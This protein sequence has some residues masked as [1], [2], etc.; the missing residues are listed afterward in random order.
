MGAACAHLTKPPASRSYTRAYFGGLKTPLRSHHPGRGRA[1][2]QLIFSTFSG[3][4][5]NQ[6]GC[7]GAGTRGGPT[8]G[9]GLPAL[10]GR[11]SP[12]L[13]VL[14]RLLPLKLLIMSATLRVE[15]FTQNQRLFAEPPPV[16]KVTP[17]QGPGAV[18]PCRLQQSREV[19][20][21][22]HSEPFVLSWL[23]RRGPT[24]ADADC[25][26]SSPCLLGL[27]HRWSPGSSR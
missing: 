27:C 15:D 1:C 18:G 16:I 22:H 7:G 11:G 20:R 8:G 6:N 24:W 10:G 12:S 17:G 9:R 19:R 4:S 26:A 21:R 13:S 5:D 3:I 2:C 23:L 25:A 14:Q